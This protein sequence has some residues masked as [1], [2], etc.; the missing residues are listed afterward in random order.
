MYD[1]NIFHNI[2]CKA[3]AHLI[4]M[5]QSYSNCLQKQ[6]Q[7]FN[8]YKAKLTHLKEETEKFTDIMGDFNI[9]LLTIDKISRQKY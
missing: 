5:L 1:L 9:S 4:N 3:P 6:K 8:I 7:I 2:N